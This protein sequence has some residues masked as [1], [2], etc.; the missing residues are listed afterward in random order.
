LT[1]KTGY[2]VWR[3]AGPVTDS[4]RAALDSFVMKSGFR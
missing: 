2:V 4:K 3:T 1:D